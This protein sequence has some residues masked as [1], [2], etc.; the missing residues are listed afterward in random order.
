M[1]DRSKGMCRFCGKEYTKS[2]MV[3][4]ISSCKYR[5]A[6]LE[7]KGN[8]KQ[9]GYFSIAV[10]G[11]YC[12]EYWLLLEVREDATLA[13]VDEFLR[14]I[15]LECC[16]HLSAFLIDGVYYDVEPMESWGRLRKTMNCRLRSVLDVGMR[17]AHEYDFGSTT[18]LTLTV[19]DYRVG[20]RHKDKIVIIARN[21]PIRVLCDECGKRPAAVVCIADG[22]VLCEHCM[23]EHECG[24][25]LASLTNSPRSGV[26]G[27]EGSEK[28]PDVL[29]R[30]TEQK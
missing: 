5:Q 14:E 2:G 15:W 20:D 7:Q 30:I 12:K 17:F 22:E 23:E 8:E 3:K 25:M 11:T 29:E 27:Y 16:G 6:W 21:N 13:D 26:C 19:F 28:Y 18:E 4:H 24:D 9:S 1:A 10:G